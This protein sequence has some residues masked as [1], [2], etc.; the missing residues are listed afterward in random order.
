MSEGGP[1]GSVRARVVRPADA[2]GPLPVIIHIHGAR[3]VFGNAPTHDR[4]VSEPAVGARAAVVFPE[5]GLSPE[6]RYP[7]TDAAFDTPS[8]RQFAEGYF[9]RR[10]GMQW[11]WGQYTTYR[12]DV[13]RSVDEWVI[14][15]AWCIPQ[16][17]PA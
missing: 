6:A 1:T 15:Q 8:Y 7:V 5:C 11:F 10:D 12:S 17:L 16:E 14:F 3:W 2:E 13:W 4:L 9:L